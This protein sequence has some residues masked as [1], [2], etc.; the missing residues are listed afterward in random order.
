MSTSRRPPTTRCVDT[1]GAGQLR[2]S[3]SVTSS[4]T[5]PPHRIFGRRP[6]RTHLRPPPSGTA[7]TSPAEVSPTAPTTVFC[8]LT[9][10][11]P[12][13]PFMQRPHLASDPGVRLCCCATAATP[14][15][16]TPN[17]RL[18]ITVGT[19]APPD[20][21]FS[22]R[23]PRRQP[24]IR[25]IL[26]Q[27]REGRGNVWG[28][29]GSHR[30]DPVRHPVVRVHPETGCKSS[31]NPGFHPP[32]PSTA[33]PTPKAAAS[34]LHAHLTKPE[35]IVRHRWRLG[36]LVLWDNRNTAHYAN[37]DYGDARRS[38]TASPPRRH[39]VGPALIGCGSGRLPCR[40]RRCG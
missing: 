21:R 12:T 24:R 32:T 7:A 14:T 27:R 40:L 35:H 3:S 18:R 19:D 16:L 17:S 26:K 37:C 11:T 22:D 30:A 28:R 5:T 4:S 29:K 33:S 25:L 9:L 8:R 23:R 10:A 1:C 39:P 13:S 15:G 31:I 20:R 2:S 6:R 34:D 38:C 36:D